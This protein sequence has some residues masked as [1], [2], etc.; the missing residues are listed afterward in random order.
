MCY[1]K[2]TLEVVGE[3]NV[4]EWNGRKYPQIIVDKFKVK[5]YNKDISLEDLL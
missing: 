3:L 4:N 2:A 5:E 1:N